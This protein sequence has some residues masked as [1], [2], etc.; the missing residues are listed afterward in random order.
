MPRP[1]Q[2][3]FRL[4]V[5]VREVPLRIECEDGIGD[6]LEDLL[7]VARLGARKMGTC[8]TPVIYP[9]R[10]ARGLFG[11]ALGALRGAAEFATQEPHADGADTNDADY[12]RLE[13][14]WHI[15]PVGIDFAQETL[16]GDGTYGFSTPLA[17]L[18]AFQGW[19]DI[20]LA[21]PPDGIRDRFVTLSG[22]LGRLTWKAVY[23]DFDAD[24]GGADYGS[25]LDFSL[26]H[27]LAWGITG[28]LE[29]A[30]YDSDGFAADT[31]KVWLTLSRSW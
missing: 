3:S 20:F 2:Q 19:A 1:P 7:T 10:L 22:R 4:G 8:T 15:D 18:H 11:H 23:H 17:T 5:D 31:R 27:P 28:K 16:G 12:H 13:A 26:A 6:A 30:D 24:R 25:E 29:Y 14:G 21:T 9:A